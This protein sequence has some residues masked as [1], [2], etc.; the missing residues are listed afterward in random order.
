MI[1][2]M[3]MDADHHEVAQRRIKIAASRI[4]AA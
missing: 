2:C 4:N 3:S 1:K